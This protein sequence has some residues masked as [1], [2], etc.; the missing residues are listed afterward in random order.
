VTKKPDFSHHSYHLQKK[1]ETTR[2]TKFGKEN[3][4]N[5]IEYGSNGNKCVMW[6]LQVTPD[7]STT[8]RL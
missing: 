6:I 2:N 1:K 8:L 7:A 3:K 5:I 4:G